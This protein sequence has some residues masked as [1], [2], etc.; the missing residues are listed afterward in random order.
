MGMGAHDTTIVTSAFYR[1][2]QV[3]HGRQA[4]FGSAL[5]V[6][7]SRPNV[8]ADRQMAEFR[9]LHS[10]SAFER[11]VGRNKKSETCTLSHKKKRIECETK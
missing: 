3:V 4:G 2:G 5:A 7:T 8:N 11:R 1:L 6:Y 9:S 10:A